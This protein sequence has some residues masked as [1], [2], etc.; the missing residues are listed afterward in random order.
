MPSVP[1]SFKGSAGGKFGFTVRG[2]QSAVRKLESFANTS[3]AKLLVAV[4]K[5]LI[6]VEAE[7]IRL[8]AGGVYWKNPIDTRRMIG[9]ITNQ[10][11]SFGFTRIEGK[12][13]TNVEY[14]IYVHEGTEMM[15]KA[16]ENRGKDGGKTGGRPFLL[17]ALNNKR[18]EISAMIIEAYKMDLY[19]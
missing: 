12:V 14:A 6:M 19:K 15:M 2:G 3:R 1:S 7:A 8:V 4:K 5:S 17:D 11:V 13:G 9:S 18:L 10:L 16:A